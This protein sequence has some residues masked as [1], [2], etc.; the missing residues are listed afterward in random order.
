MSI[1]NT[2][3]ELAA[4]RGCDKTICPSEVARTLWPQQWR[5]HMDEV[6]QTAYILRD[7][8]KVLISQKGRQ[9]PGEAVKGPI[10]IRIL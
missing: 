1:A 2:I 9:V 3:L 8:G 7:E 4:A 10:R 6:R 5:K